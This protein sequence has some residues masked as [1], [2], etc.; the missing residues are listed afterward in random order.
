M[1][2]S[3][4][5]WRKKSSKRRAEV[6]PTSSLP[7]KTPCAI[8]HQSFKVLWL[9]LTISYWGKHLCHLH[10]P[11]HRE[12]PLWKDSSLLPPLPHQCLSSLLGPKDD[13]LH[14]ILWRVCLWAEPLQRQL[15]EEP[16]APRV[17]RSLPGSEHSSQ[18]TLRHLAGTLTW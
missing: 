15:W 16:P 17:K 13:T 8:A 2:T 4:W 12:L 18:A 1:A 14:Q 9:P 7:V 3:C 6:K 11:C 5:T 10:L